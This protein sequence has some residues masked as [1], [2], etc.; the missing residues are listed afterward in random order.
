[1]K[2]MRHILCLVVAVSFVT[3]LVSCSTVPTN[4]PIVKATV[5]TSSGKAVVNVLAEDATAA[6]QTGG[7]YRL[8]DAN[9]VSPLRKAG[10]ET[11]AFAWK[12][13]KVVGIS[14]I[15]GKLQENQVEPL[16]LVSY[17]SGK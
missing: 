5:T 3:Q 13:A 2:T 15:N 12:L 17:H 6:A 8:V 10:Q 16:P 11:A 14:Y 1:M 9:E 4:K 7:T